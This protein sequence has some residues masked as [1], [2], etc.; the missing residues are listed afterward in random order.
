MYDVLH[1]IRAYFLQLKELKM[2]NFLL[3][4]L[5]TFTP[6]VLAEVYVTVAPLK[7]LSA[8][9][10]SVYPAKAEPLDTSSISAGISAEILEI[11]ARPGDRVV[12]GSVLLRMDCRD[13]TLVRDRTDRLLEEAQLKLAYTR[14]QAARV[15][16]LAE[17]NIASEELRDT[18]NTDVAMA[19]ID[20]IKRR[21]ALQEAR[22]SVSHCQVAAPFDA[23]VIDQQAS[24]G[25]RVTVGSPILRLVSQSV[26]V[27]ARVPLDFR[28]EPEQ[29]FVF[30]SG[31][32]RVPLQVITFS[33]AVDTETGTRLVRFDAGLSRLEPGVPGRIVVQTSGLVL[34]ADYLVERGGQYGLMTSKKSRAIFILRSQAQ[35]GQPVDVSDLSG[36]L[37]IIRDGRF[38]ARQGDALVISE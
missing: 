9:V 12:K 22:L 31:L 4:W 1:E 33:K 27:R 25:T 30:E 19:E 15:A 20:V 18:R 34:P 7:A 3:G 37:L 24:V 29:Q 28:V 13:I 5:I 23:I 35:L 2:Q 17:T 8:H 10:E 38:R 6:M 11:K 14:R 36:D 26:D 16:K 32:G 21:I